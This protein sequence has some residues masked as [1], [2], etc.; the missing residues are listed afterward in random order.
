[1]ERSVLLYDAPGLSTSARTSYDW[2]LRPQPTTCARSALAYD[3]YGPA[4]APVQFRGGGDAA[5][6]HVKNPLAEPIRRR[7]LLLLR[8][9]ARTRT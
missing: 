2:G 3:D 7:V 4:E 9:Q 1:M 5:V 8:W 6:E